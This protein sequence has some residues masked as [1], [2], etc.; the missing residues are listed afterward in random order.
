MPS[1]GPESPSG[2]KRK[3]EGRPSAVKD[4]E[5]HDSYPPYSTSPAG[6]LQVVHDNTHRRLKSRHIQLIGIGGYAFEVTLHLFKS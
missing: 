3:L 6:S 1:T 5:V 4:V 2:V